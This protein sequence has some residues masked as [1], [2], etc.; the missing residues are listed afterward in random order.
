MKADLSRVLLTIALTFAVLCTGVLPVVAFGPLDI[1]AEVPI[2]S[3]YVWRGQVVNDEAVVQPSV[4]ADVMGFGV[5]FWTNFDLSDYNGTETEFNEVDLTLNY[6]LPIPLPLL[7]INFGLIYYDFPNTDWDSTAEFYLTGSA[8]LPFHPTLEFYYDFKEI[9]GLYVNASVSRGV[10]LTPELN[11]DLG[12]SLGYG[13]GDYNTGY[14]G[15]GNAGVNN[16][17]LTAGVPFHPVPL[18]TVTPHV[19]Y[20]TLV[21]DSKDSVDARGGK[22]DAFYMGLSAAFRF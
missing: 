1:E 18:F 16:L 11:L 4:K 7:D 9:D 10:P 15:Q 20:A 19:G 14:H 5:G 13:D 8:S 6:G 12:L 17:L 22:T 3:K 2:Y 21:S